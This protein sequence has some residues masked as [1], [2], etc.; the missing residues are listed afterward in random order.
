MLKLEP[1]GTCVIC[2]RMLYRG[3]DTVG[4][5]W[6]YHNPEGFVC[7]N[8]TGV[9]AWY[10]ELLDKANQELKNLGAICQELLD[11]ANQELKNLGAI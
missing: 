1:V 9:E 2:K 3:G 6:Y 4:I 7:K 11:K 5:D 8:H 10:Q